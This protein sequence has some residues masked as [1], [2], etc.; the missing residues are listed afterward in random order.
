MGFRC[1]NAKTMPMLQ[2]GFLYLRYV[3]NPRELWE[4]IQPY[5]KD[6]EVIFSS[7]FSCYLCGLQAPFPVCLSQ[8]S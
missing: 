3:G 1:L 8:V 7:F 6:H 2:V 4:W 5:V